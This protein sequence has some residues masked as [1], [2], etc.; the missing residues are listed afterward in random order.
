MAKGGGKFTPQTTFLTAI[1]T[2][3]AIEGRNLVTFP[4][5]VQGT[6]WRRQNFLITYQESKMAAQKPEMLGKWSKI[7]VSYLL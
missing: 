1:S 2:P 5:N 6:K 7:D 3:F 4:K